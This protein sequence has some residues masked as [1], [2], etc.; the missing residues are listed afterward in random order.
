MITSGWQKVVKFTH[1]ISKGDS[2][3]CYV[4][5]VFQKVFKNSIALLTSPFL[6][7]LQTFFTQRALKDKLGTPSSL[8][9]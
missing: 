4:K 9:H 3:K 7:I 8:G 6:V 1:L 5:F 2:N